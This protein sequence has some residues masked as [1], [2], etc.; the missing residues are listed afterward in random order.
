MAD[1]SMRSHAR[2]I[3]ARSASSHL[4]ATATPTDSDPAADELLH[5]VRNPRSTLPVRR[6]GA[7]RRTVEVEAAYAERARRLR[8]AVTADLAEAGVL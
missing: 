3:D 6:P 2:E 4:S 5:R 7:V 8:A 1:L